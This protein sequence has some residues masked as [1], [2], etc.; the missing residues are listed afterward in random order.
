MCGVCRR[1][2]PSARSVR[3]G[4]WHVRHLQPRAAGKLPHMQARR[5]YS[6]Y[7]ARTTTQ[8]R[9]CQVV[10]HDRARPADRPSRP[11]DAAIGTARHQG[12][13]LPPPSCA[14]CYHDRP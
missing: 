11:R 10:H 3:H 2:K 6:T 4:R 5:V 8:A 13:V 14:A 12:R 7:S 9:R 1:P